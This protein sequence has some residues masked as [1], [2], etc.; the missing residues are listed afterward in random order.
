MVHSHE[1]LEKMIGNMG[2]VEGSQ[3]SFSL[4][5]SFSLHTVLALFS[6]HTVSPCSL[7]N[8]IAKL[9]TWQFQTPK[10]M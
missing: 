2:S 4:S 10:D 3:S 1:A 8:K 6:F 7:P 9:L 5:P